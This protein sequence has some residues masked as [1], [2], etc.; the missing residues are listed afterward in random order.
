M[1]IKIL[2]SC[3]G[4]NFS[5]IAGETADVDAALGKDLVKAGYAEEIKAASKKDTKSKAGD[6][7]D[8]A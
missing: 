3:S 8:D 1:K 4:L 7:A 5:F 6:S 2:K